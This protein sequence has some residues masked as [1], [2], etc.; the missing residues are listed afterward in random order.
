MKTILFG[1]E[2]RKEI[3]KGVDLIAKAV[4]TSYGPKGN[5]TIVYNNDSIDMTN[6]GVTIVRAMS[7][8]PLAD[9]GAK[10]GIKL[11]YDAANMTNKSVGDGTSLTTLLTAF[12]INNIENRELFAE[13]APKVIAGL[14]S[15]ILSKTK[16]VKTKKALRDIATVS[17][18]SEDIGKVVSDV[19]YQV[20][21]RGVVDMSISQNDE[22]VG[23][24][25]K[26]M[27]FDYGYKSVA[28][29]N[30]PKGFEAENIRVLV[31]EGDI[32]TVD[33]FY[34]IMTQLSSQGEKEL[35]IVC[36]S[37]TEEVVQRLAINNR[38]KSFSA[39]VVEAPKEKELRQNFYKDISV[40]TGAV[41]NGSMNM[42]NLGYAKKVICDKGRTTIINDP[43][44]EDV[45]DV[46]EELKGLIKEYEAEGNKP[47]VR[48]TE[49]RL[50]FFNG[51]IGKIKVGGQTESQTRA[52][53][54]LVDDAINAAKAAMSDGVLAGGGSILIRMENELLDSK[55]N[56]A[57]VFRKAFLDVFDLMVKNTGINTDGLMVDE[58]SKYLCE[59][60]CRGMDFNKGV[61]VEDMFE[62]GI[63]DPAPVMIEALKNATSTALAFLSTEVLIIK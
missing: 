54:Y 17:S 49:R 22:V 4:G 8:A 24:I 5:N 38:N 19:V 35:L 29:S 46:I 28:L 1:D 48:E 40:V 14:N 9:I 18:R 43:N 60:N 62:Y 44:K 61:R 7:E 34:N 59:D 42:G 53:V 57:D 26:G 55:Y 3:K 10:V 30:T 15:F 52:K 56:T 37:A 45:K 16:T 50:A 39:M 58:L 13:E 6:D 51:G 23:E 27:Q 32:E 47:K 41:T 63:V 2:A 21:E 25:V 12:L 31:F 33:S 20:G 11:M 36:H